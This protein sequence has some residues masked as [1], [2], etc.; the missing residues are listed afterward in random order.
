[1]N[2][3]DADG[4]V[5]SGRQLPAAKD[6]IRLLQQNEKNELM[7]SDFPVSN[8]EE[9]D[10]GSVTAKSKISA[11]PKPDANLSTSDLEALIDF[12]QTLQ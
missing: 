6:T 10:D 1:M 9:M 3:V 12:V 8:L 7:I 5:H 2:V 4:L 11:M